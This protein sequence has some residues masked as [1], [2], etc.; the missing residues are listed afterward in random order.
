MKTIDELK[1]EQEA[2]IARSKEIENQINEMLQHKRA[3][4]I[5]EVKAKIQEFGLTLEET[6]GTPRASGRRK[7]TTEKK[8]GSVKAKYRDPETGKTWS[9]RGLTPNWLK[10]K[11][12]KDQYLIG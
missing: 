11:E 10:D 12:N 3:E 1:A 4:A 7:A 6:F 2:I 9:G 8:I 5:S